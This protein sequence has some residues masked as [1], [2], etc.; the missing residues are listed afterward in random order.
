MVDL[1]LPLQRE[2]RF[3]ALTDEWRLV[4][5]E[6]FLDAARSPALS[7]AFFVPGVTHRFNAWAQYQ[8]LQR[9]DSKN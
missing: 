4:L 5:E 1:E 7:R 3:A 6:R 8:L 9:R 2:T